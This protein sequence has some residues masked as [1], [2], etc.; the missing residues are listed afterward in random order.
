[1]KLWVVFFALLVVASCATAPPQYPREDI[2]APPAVDGDAS[3]L[4]LLDYVRRDRYQVNNKRYAEWVLDN[5]DYERSFEELNHTF[6]LTR[7][8]RPYGLS[9]DYAAMSI[10]TGETIRLGVS[11]LQLPN[12]RFTYQVDM[13]G[14][15][16][17]LGRMKELPVQEDYDGISVVAYQWAPPIDPNGMKAADATCLGRDIRY[18]AQDDLRLQAVFA[19]RTNMEGFVGTLRAIYPDMVVY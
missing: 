10:R 4:D 18:Q 5:F 7:E 13:S 14:F 3:I 2:E 9:R 12:G 11:R 6:F 15:E 19:E 1:M 17:C 16:L 8:F